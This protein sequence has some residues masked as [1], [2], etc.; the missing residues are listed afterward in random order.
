MTTHELKTWPEFF[1]V[2]ISGEKTFE[3]R[4]DDRVFRAGDTLHLREW[5][6]IDKAYTGREAWYRV[7]YLMCGEAF[8]LRKDWVCMAI[9]P[10]SDRTPPLSEPK[11][12]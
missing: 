6:P 12:K 9:Q 4:R 11:E 7:T 3:L 1:H 8:G 2:V 10:T 5:L